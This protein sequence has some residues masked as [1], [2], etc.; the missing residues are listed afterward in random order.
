[1][2]HRRNSTPPQAHQPGIPGAPPGAI[3]VAVLP[4]Q[5]AIA[6]WS[7]LRDYLNRSLEWADGR[8]TEQ[9]LFAKIV[10]GQNILLTVVRNPS[11][12]R[13]AAP[14]GPDG[15]E[16]IGVAVVEL[17]LNGD[18]LNVVAMALDN[19][20][21]CFSQVIGGLRMCFQPPTWIECYS[22]RPGMKRFL[23]G[24][25]WREAIAPEG[26]PAGFKRFVCG[27]AFDDEKAIATAQAVGICP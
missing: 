20:A 7:G 14:T 22:R 8:E 18:T 1:M 25:G 2:D 16:L 13:I 19:D 10:H 9:S 3:F 11:V 17:S 21:K 6:Q 23:E 15:L 4:P 12:L 24:F 5:A 26:V 27:P